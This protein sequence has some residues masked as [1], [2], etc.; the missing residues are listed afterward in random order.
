MKEQES[1]R[2]PP[3]LDDPSDGRQKTEEERQ[4]DDEDDEKWRFEAKVRE[5]DARLRRIE[6]R[7]YDEGVSGQASAEG[8]G[9]R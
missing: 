7:I 9:D 6:E 3:G 1:E 4:M 5:M 2:S 8:A